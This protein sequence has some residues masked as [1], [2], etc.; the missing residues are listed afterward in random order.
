MSNQ[1][2]YPFD[3]LS[4]FLT[5]TPLAVHSYTKLFD[6]DTASLR[7]NATNIQ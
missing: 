6:V 1:L 5:K 4:G 2:T 7:R 3:G